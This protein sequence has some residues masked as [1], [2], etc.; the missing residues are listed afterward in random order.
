[1]DTSTCLAC[2]KP[3]RALLSH[4]AKNSKC[5]AEKYPPDVFEK[6]KTRCHE[7]TSEAHNLKRR[8]DYDPQAESARKRARVDPKAEAERKRQEY[9]RH[10]IAKKDKMRIFNPNLRCTETSSRRF[11]LVQSFPVFVA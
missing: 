9:T 8:Q 11:T 6:L 2:K 3:F 10:Q 1:M 4:L 7:L 5:K